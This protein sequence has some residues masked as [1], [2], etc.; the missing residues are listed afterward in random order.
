MDDTDN[1]DF[2]I[3]DKYYDEHW[4]DPVYTTYLDK[5]VNQKCIIDFTTFEIVSGKHNNSNRNIKVKSIAKHI[6][7]SGDVLNND[8]T[9][10]LHAPIRA[11]IMMFKNRGIDIR[12]L[13]KKKVS[14]KVEFTVKTIRTYTLLYHEILEN[15][16]NESN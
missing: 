15:E 12:K 16:N 13:I 6:S 8:T 10:Y 2:S 7:S 11:F 14:L 5:G 3:I 4:Q 9:F 1:L